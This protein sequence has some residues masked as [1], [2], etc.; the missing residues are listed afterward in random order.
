[1]NSLEF[2]I[3]VEKI[4]AFCFFLPLDNDDDD[5][6]IDVDGD[7]DYDSDHKLA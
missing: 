6:D 5:D 3:T 1:M 7:D 2:H 4:T